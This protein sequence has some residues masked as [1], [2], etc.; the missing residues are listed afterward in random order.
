MKFPI[1]SSDPTSWPRTYSH[2]WEKK[3]LDSG[4]KMDQNMRIF[5]HGDVGFLFWL[6]A[7]EPF[8]FC[9]KKV[10]GP[11][12]NSSHTVHIFIFI[13]L[14]HTFLKHIYYIIVHTCMHALHYIALHCITLH[15]IR[16]DYIT[17]H[18]ISCIYIWL[19]IHTAPTTNQL[20]SCRESMN[21]HCTLRHLRVFLVLG[22][23]VHTS[24]AL[25]AHTISENPKKIAVFWGYIYI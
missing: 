3:M 21:S 24:C 15:Y 14:Y 5:V 7:W 22:A 13:F 18:Y 10:W 4:S 20:F 12:H 23:K 9:W 1:A 17:L 2:V 8:P 6:G 19:Y 11:G 16:L 25:C